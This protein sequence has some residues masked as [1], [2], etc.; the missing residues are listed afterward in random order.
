MDLRI[1][2]AE[3]DHLNAVTHQQDIT[4]H[5]RMVPCFAF[6]GWEPGKLS[7]LVWSC[8]DKSYLTLLCQYHQ[9]VLVSQQNELTTVSATFPFASAF[10]DIDTFYKGAAKA[11]SKIIVND[12]VIK[13][14]FELDRIQALL[15]APSIRFKGDF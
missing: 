1:L 8:I 4:N 15:N 12:K 11:E 5:N 13:V 10:Y 6:Y 14:G 3:C 2:Q 9:Q 7:E